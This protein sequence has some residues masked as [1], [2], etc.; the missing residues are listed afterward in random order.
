MYVSIGP[1]GLNF[2]REERK[3]KKLKQGKNTE[4]HVSTSILS[5]GCTDN[6]FCELFI[7]FE[8]WHGQK[9]TL[10]VSGED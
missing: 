3:E 1:L 6:G 8:G 2:D 7:L 10:P 4:L 5:Q 9:I